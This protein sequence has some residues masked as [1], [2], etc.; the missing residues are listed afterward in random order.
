MVKEEEYLANKAGLRKWVTKTILTGLLL[1]AIV[2]YIEFYF[3]VPVVV[4]T[5]I[6]ITIVLF[7]GFLHEWLHYWQA[8][9]LGYEPKWY[10]TRFTMGFEISHKSARGKWLKDK[11]KI[12]LSPYVVIMPLSFIIVF[13]GYVIGNIGILIAGVASIL[14]HIITY[15]KEGV[16]VD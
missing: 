3:D 16:R 6:G 11:R 14:L 7:L 2:Y 1:I 4:D 5:I 15:K 10:R 9:K 13:I 8:V 12:A